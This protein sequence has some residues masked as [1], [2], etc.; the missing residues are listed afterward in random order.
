ML[1]GSG[2]R[3]H[4]LEKVESNYL[5]MLRDKNTRTQ[6]FGGDVAAPAVLT[7]TD[8][9]DIS[10]LP[11]E[12]LE[13]GSQAFVNEEV[14]FSAYDGWMYKLAATEKSLAKPAILFGVAYFTSFK[15]SPENNVDECQLKGGDGLLYAFNLHYGTSVYDVGITL[16]LGNKVPPSPTW[17]VEDEFYCLN[18]GTQDPTDPDS[19]DH[20]KLIE[21]IAVDEN[22]PTKTTT[23]GFRTIQNYIFRQ[24]DNN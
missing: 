18:C 19:E 17:I 14:D 5:Y 24:E 22:D 8:L 1:V 21:L 11:F 12:G 9:K 23:P 16:E 3:S 20:G 7:P 10:D 6:T 2:N 4:P 13:S 15:P